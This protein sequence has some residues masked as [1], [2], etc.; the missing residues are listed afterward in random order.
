MLF[1]STTNVSTRLPNGLPVATGLFPA[2]SAVAQALGA[3]A[4]KPEK[5]KNLTAGMTATFGGID[6]SIDFYRIALHDRVNAISTQTV[7][8]DPSAGAAYDNYLALVG[9]GVVGAESI[10]G[11]FYFTNAFDTITKGIDFVATTKV[12]MGSAGMTSL[13]LAANY[14]KTKFDGDIDDLFN[15]ESQYDFLYGEPNWRGIFTAIHNVG[16]F[17]GLARVSYYGS[18]SNSN[19]SPITD[20]Q[21]FGKEFMV[22]LELSYTFMDHY[23]V[24]LGARN[25]LDNYPDP[26]AA[27]LGETGQGRVYRSDSIVDW[28][29]GYYY[30][31]VEVSF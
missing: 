1:R 18:Y 13:S 20:I 21:D 27:A 29:G 3:S 31:R 16:D 15:A 19:G 25:V 14:N 30:G 2:S 24:A 10:G 12:D 6:L 22:D 17:T 11:V 7:S 5:S 4:L 28:Q 8:S 9:A 26:G 23:K